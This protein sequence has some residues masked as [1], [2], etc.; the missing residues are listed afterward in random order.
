MRPSTFDSRMGFLATKP[1]DCAAAEPPARTRPQKSSVTAQFLIVFICFFPPKRRLKVR[2]PLLR[3]YARQRLRPD[4][5]A[6]S[7]TPRVVALGLLRPVRLP[8]TP[9]AASRR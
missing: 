9:P 2:P 3:L 4:A 5:P 7:H 1:G 6:N 8:S